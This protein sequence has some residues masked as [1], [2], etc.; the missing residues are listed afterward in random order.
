[1]GNTRANNRRLPSPLGRGTAGGWAL[2]AGSGLGR[3]MRTLTMLTFDDVVA[4]THVVNG[5]MGEMAFAGT[6]AGDAGVIGIPG[7]STGEAIGNPIG[8]TG[9]ETFGVCHWATAFAG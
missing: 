4:T 9:L 3:A 5:G 8:I 6:G 1:M 7:Y 2:T